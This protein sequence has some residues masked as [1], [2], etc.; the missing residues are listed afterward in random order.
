RFFYR[1]NHFR[2]DH[3]D[4]VSRVHALPCVAADAGKIRSA[5]VRSFRYLSAKRRDLHA[6]HAR[7]ASWGMGL[8]HARTD[9]G[10]GALLLN[11]ES[12]PGG[13]RAIRNW[14]Y[15]FI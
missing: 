2:C 11:Y 13:R 12:G 9:L 8:D 5:G 15:L 14:G 7:S 6:I 4:A 3:A 1:H 10:P